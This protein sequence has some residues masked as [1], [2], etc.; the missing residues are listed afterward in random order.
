MRLYTY[1]ISFLFLLLFLQKAQAQTADTTLRYKI[2]PKREFRGVWIA[3]VENIDWPA[4]GEKA[5]EQQQQLIDIL[6]AHQRTGINEVFFQVRPAADAF[7]S[8]STEPWSKWLN[9]KQG[10]APNP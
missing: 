2:A 6:D 7:Y 1:I 10:L 9:G 3:T 5:F 4:K 8:N